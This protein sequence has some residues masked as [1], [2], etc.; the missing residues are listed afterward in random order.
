MYTNL[1]EAAPYVWVSFWMSLVRFSVVCKLDLLSWDG[2]AE[3][4]ALAV[5]KNQNMDLSHNGYSAM[6]SSNTVSQEK[7]GFHKIYLLAYLE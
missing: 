6:G 2:F 5:C 4:S 7:N 1:R 3:P